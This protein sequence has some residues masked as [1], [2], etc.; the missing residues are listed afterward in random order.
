[1]S[2]NDE[3]YEEIAALRAWKAKAQLLGGAVI[4]RAEGK[5]RSDEIVFIAHPAHVQAFYYH[6]R[7]GMNDASNGQVHHGGGHHTTVAAIDHQ[8]D[9]VLQ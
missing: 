5:S 8:I 1:M 7:S 6:I 4:G 9:T 2:H 3:V